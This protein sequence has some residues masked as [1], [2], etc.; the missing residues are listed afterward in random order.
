MKKIAVDTDFALSHPFESAIA[1]VQINQSSS[2]NECK[3]L[4]L[5]SLRR[6]HPKA[7]GSIEHGISLA[8]RALK[9]PEN[10]NG[11]SKKI[12]WFAF[13]STEVE[14]KRASF[15]N[16][17][18]VLSNRRRSVLPVHFESQLF[19]NDISLF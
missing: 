11:I 19:L 14:I 1:N 4:A 3:N 10:E 7:T 13:Y 9:K 2:L 17:C 12:R 6:G 16:A 15:S 5:D 8:Q 18:Y